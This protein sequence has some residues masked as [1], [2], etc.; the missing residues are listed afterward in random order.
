MPV[1]AL[2]AEVLVS[3]QLLAEH[4]ASPDV[5]VD[6]VVLE[7][8]DCS[9][10][11]LPWLVEVKVGA[12]SGNQTCNM[13]QAHK[14]RLCKILQDLDN[15]FKLNMGCFV[16]HSISC[17]NFALFGGKSSGKCREIV[18]IFFVFNC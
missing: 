13:S 1:I 6:R 8:E 10:E 4:E 18:Y 16:I 15:F 9:S 14:Q 3:Q 2:S 11:G 7:G 12:W 17:P 5:G